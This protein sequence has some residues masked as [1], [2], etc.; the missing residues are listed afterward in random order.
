MENVRH[1]EVPFQST[2]VFISNIVITCITFISSRFPV[3]QEHGAW[4]MGHGAT[5]CFRVMCISFYATCLAWSM[6]HI[7]VLPRDISKVSAVGLAQQ[8]E[9]S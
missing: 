1:E 7:W 3:E 5:Q 2:L 6:Q 4:S 8:A 9:T